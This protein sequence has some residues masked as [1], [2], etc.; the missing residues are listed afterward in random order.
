MGQRGGL[1]PALRLVGIGWTVVAGIALGLLAGWLLDGVLGTGEVFLVVGLFA[2]LFFG[3]MSA[4][5][6]LK[7][8]LDAISRRRTGGKG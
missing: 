6:Q 8:V 5:L 2:G 3:L 4:Y 1:P 7:E